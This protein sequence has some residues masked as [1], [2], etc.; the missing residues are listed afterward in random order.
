[1]STTLPVVEKFHS[2]QGEGAH[3]GRSAFFIR[4]ASCNVKCPWCDTKNSWS[5]DNHP[6]ETLIALAKTVVNAQSQG[7]GFVVITG[8]EPLH[9]NLNPLC[10][11]I[12]KTTLNNKKETIPIHLETSGVNELSGKPDWITL[13]PKKHAL[14]R[15]EILGACNELKI[16]IHNDDDLLFAE[17]MAKKAQEYSHT[18]TNP[19]L[20]LQ[21][22]WEDEKGEKLA[23]EYVKSNPNW[24]LSIQTHKWLGIL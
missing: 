5:E 17:K 15:M 1:M 2:L 18:K 4:L 12:R 7:A 14:P 21:P 10:K 22:G 24:R 23:F 3:S 16:V 13:S 11:T 20:Y 19:L 9:H 8:G 6:K